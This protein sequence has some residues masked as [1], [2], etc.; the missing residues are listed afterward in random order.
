VSE[1]DFGRAG[2]V[3]LIVPAWYAVYTRPNHEKRVGEHFASREIEYYLPTYR[4]TSHWKNRLAV[5]VERP[6]FPT[7]IFARIAWNQHVRILEVP[8]VISFVGTAR[9]PLPL[10]SAEI[11]TLRLGLKG[12]HAQPH[13]Y[14][15]IGERVRI[16]SGLLAGMQGIVLRMGSG[17]R[18]VLTI[19]QIRKSIV[20]EV[21]QADVETMV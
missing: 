10:S 15:N 12:V 11:E 14:L 21:D 13:P 9:E 19:E 17:L 4:T 5:E 8:S 1:S 6:L 16:K 2:R 3:D 7:Y 18:V 20:V